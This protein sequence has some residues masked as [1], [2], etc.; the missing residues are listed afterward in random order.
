[1][2]SNNFITVPRDEWD[3]L[4]VELLRLYAIERR[5]ISRVKIPDETLDE[6]INN[7][8][9]LEDRLWV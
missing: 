2:I 5:V 6:Y 1:M 3:E 9:K 4:Q 8:P 7:L